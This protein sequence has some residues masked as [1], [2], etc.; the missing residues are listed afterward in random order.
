MTRD[1]VELFTWAH[2]DLVDEICTLETLAQADDALIAELVE[3]L[4]NLYLDVA[5]YPGAERSQNIDRWLAK[6][7]ALL[8]RAGERKS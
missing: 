6:I 5:P 7:D 3:G 1:R 4:R 2:E 8:K